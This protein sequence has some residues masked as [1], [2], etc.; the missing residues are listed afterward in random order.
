M[1]IYGI[2]NDIIEV[3]RILKS[4]KNHRDHFLDKLFTKNEQEYCKKFSSPEIHFAGRYAAKEA[5]SKALG[6]GFGEELKWLEFEI[7]NDKKGK[8]E[9]IFSNGSRWEDCQILLSISHCKDY[10]SAVAICLK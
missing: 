6:T 9:V 7:I 8:P 2:G 4:I 1:E 3:K 5:V 10:A